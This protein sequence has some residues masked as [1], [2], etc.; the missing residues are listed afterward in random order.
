MADNPTKEALYELLDYLE[1]VETKC[2]AL[3]AFFRANGTITD[4]AIAPYLKQADDATDVKSRA[5][6]ARFDYLFD[7]EDTVT[8]ATDANP[9][10]PQERPREESASRT[11]GSA[12][13][14]EPADAHPQES[15]P[16]QKPEAA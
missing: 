12:K 5:I 10:P 9:Q 15:E 7:T 11:E 3:M 6:R 16:E 4:D 13:S 1:Q 8:P 14:P 2:G